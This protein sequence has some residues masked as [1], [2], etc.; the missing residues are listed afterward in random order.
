M[1]RNE[2]HMVGSL[3]VVLASASILCAAPQGGSLSSSNFPWFE[4]QVSPSPLNSAGESRAKALALYAEALK[5]RDQKGFDEAIPL[6]R[7]VSELD[8]SFLQV[9]LAIAA[10]Y[11]QFNEPDK[12]REEL[13]TGLKANPNAAELKAALA[14]SLRLQKKY[15]EALKLAQET[16][17]EAPEQIA[18]YRVILEIYSAQ[19]KTAEALKVVE[20]AA[21]QKSSRAIFWTNLAKL[22]TEL[23]LTEGTSSEVEIAQKVLPLYQKAVHCEKPTA[24]LYLQ[25]GDCETVLNRHAEAL[26]AFQGALETGSTTA[27]IYWRIGT[28]QQAMGNLK[29]AQKSYESAFR[30]NPNLPGLWKTLASNYI[31]QGQE[32]QAIRVLEQVLRKNPTKAAIYSALGELYEKAQQMDKAEASYHQA[33]QLAPE[34]LENHLTLAMIQLLQK[35]SKEAD[36]TL[37]NAQKLFPASARIAFWQGVVARENKNY[38]LALNCFAQAKAMAAGEEQSMLNGK[39]YLEVSGV[40]ELAGK[41]DE[42]EATLK[43]GLQKEPQN[44]ELMN[45]L[46][47][48]YAEK[49]KN[50]DEALKLSRRSLKISPDNGA[51]L[52]TLGWIYFKRNQPDVALPLLQRA[53]QESKEDLVV[54]DH[55][56]E[57]LASL[58]RKNEATAIWKKIL[59][60]DPSKS[61]VRS[62]L[63]IALKKS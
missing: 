14:Y 10:H 22:Y 23:L 56:A 34:Q 27:E 29:E 50:L 24:D 11:W 38:D 42:M 61:D 44:D 20:K 35:K 58:N 6:L 2:W 25:L 46:A 47:Y 49:G 52:D 1:S 57:C 26:A 55:A 8:P 51:Y 32:D 13:Q 30:I 9:Y 39:F 18:A 62:K 19:G 16:L 4:E 17:A 31:A 7:Q 37:K 40:Q 12:A 48:S 36:E 15:D 28:T 3:A 45:A 33:M 60:R 54:L 5:V 53:V 63:E 21:Q 41:F 43:E 59:D